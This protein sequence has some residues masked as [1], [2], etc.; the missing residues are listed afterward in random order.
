MRDLGRLLFLGPT[1]IPA[2]LKIAA[3]S[4]IGSSRSNSIAPSIT[5]PRLLALFLPTQQGRGGKE[6]S[7]SVL[8]GC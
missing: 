1:L 4:L 8:Y 5:R 6:G 7:D 3:A 2:S